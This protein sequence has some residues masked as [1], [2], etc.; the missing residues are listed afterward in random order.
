LLDDPFT[1]RAERQEAVCSF[2][3]EAS[4]PLRLEHPGI[5]KV[6]AHWSE[7]VNSGPF[8]LAI[9]FIPGKTLEQMLDEKGPIAWRQAAE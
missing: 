6:H 5:P 3:Q 7:T 1:T 9:D 4:T 2:R 8:Y